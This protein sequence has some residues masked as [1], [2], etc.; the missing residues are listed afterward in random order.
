MRV[1]ADLAMA[2]VSTLTNPAWSVK[3]VAKTVAQAKCKAGAFVCS[4][5]EILVFRWTEI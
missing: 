1:N 3:L 5:S 2:L 4:A